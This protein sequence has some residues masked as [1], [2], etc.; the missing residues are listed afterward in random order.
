MPAAGQLGDPLDGGLERVGERE[1]R[2]RLADDADDRLRALQ[3]PRD[4]L[5]APAAPQGKRRA[6]GEGREELQLLLRRAAVLERELKGPDGGSPSASVAVRWP[7]PFPAGVA[8]TP[9]GRSW[10]AA[11]A[12]S[13]DSPDVAGLLVP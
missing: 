3:S 9:R 8:T 2:D 10:S 5:D 6:R 11:S 7:L 1:L 13:T 4:E 12:C